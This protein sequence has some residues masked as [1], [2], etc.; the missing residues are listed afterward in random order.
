MA[1]EQLCL[2]DELAIREHGT[3]MPLIFEFVK[4]F[5]GIDSD[6]DMIILRKVTRCRDAAAWLQ[7]DHL[8]LAALYQ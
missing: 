3:G 8:L 6:P 4:G 1:I 5:S 7:L 2:L